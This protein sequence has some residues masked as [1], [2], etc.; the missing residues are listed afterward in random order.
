M[1]F[2]VAGPRPPDR[3]EAMSV[4][5]TVFPADRLFVVTAALEY[6]SALVGD[7]PIAVAAIKAGQPL[8]E[9]RYG[10]SR[11]GREVTL[12][13]R[14]GVRTADGGFVAA[15]D[16]IGA[17]PARRLAGAGGLMKTVRWL[18]GK[19]VTN[20]PAGVPVKYRSQSG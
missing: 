15:M 1:V 12:S 5:V 17:G 6:N 10:T 9:V 14:V 4:A 3:S 20:L 16:P 2:G 11:S 8:I 19:A 7:D 18:T 13:I